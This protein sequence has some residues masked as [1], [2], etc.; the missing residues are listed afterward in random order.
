MKCLDFFPLCLAG[1]LHFENIHALLLL[2]FLKLFL[3]LP[4]LYPYIAFS[5]PFPVQTKTRIISSMP[6]TLRRVGWILFVA[7]WARY[8]DAALMCAATVPTECQV[9]FALFF[10]LFLMVLTEPVAAGGWSNEEQPDEHYLE[11]SS[12]GD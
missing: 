7:G 10:C 5:P 9:D 4:P 3:F 11:L 2:T 1:F 12:G 6:Q 8:A